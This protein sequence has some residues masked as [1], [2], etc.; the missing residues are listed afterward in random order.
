MRLLSPPGYRIFITFYRT[1][2]WDFV[3][4]RVFFV[5]QFWK[6]L[7]ISLTFIRTKAKVGIIW[8][9]KSKQ[10]GVGI[11][12]MSIY[13]K[14]WQSKMQTSAL[15]SLLKPFAFSFYLG[16]TNSPRRIMNS[17][18]YSKCLYYTAL[19]SERKQLCS[20]SSGRDWIEPHFR[21]HFPQLYHTRSE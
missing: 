5:K 7:G 17:T 16:K 19:I 9:C 21:A 6:F 20:R 18:W 15:I 11:G 2:T 3:F 4:C 13:M 12:Y 10:F 8:Y 14:G 1:F